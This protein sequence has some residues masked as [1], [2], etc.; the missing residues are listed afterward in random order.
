MAK[1]KTFEKYLKFRS[2]FE[3]DC[4][5][6]YE[7]GKYGLK[8]EDAHSFA[9]AASKDWKYFCSE[10]QYS[11]DL[12]KDKKNEIIGIDWGV[13]IN[14]RRICRSTGMQ[15]NPQLLNTGYY[16]DLHAPRPYVQYKDQIEDIITKIK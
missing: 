16:I 5:Y 3:E 15:Y 12:L 4:K 10:E 8:D 11:A 13:H 2:T 1:G 6:I 7:S 9:K 14:L